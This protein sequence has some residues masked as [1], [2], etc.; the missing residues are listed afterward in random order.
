[1][2]LDEETVDLVY[3]YLTRGMTEESKS[4]LNDSYVSNDQMFKCLGEAVFNE[5]VVQA[6]KQS[7]TKHMDPDG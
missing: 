5:T 6:V 4:F 2:E 3:G 7:I 1:M